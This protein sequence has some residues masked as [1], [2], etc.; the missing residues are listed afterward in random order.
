MI[1][2]FS[3]GALKNDLADSNAWSQD[4]WK[5]S[6][7][8]DLQDLTVVDSAAEQ[9]RPSYE[10]TSPHSSKAASSLKPTANISRKFNPFHG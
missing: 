6:Q 9:T 8:P 10:M 1:G 3:L 2:G 5:R 4:K 7:I